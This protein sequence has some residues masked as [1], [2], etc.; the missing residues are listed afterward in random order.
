MLIRHGCRGQVFGYHCHSASFHRI[1]LRVLVNTIERCGCLTQL[2]GFYNK[3][4]LTKLELYKLRPSSRPAGIASR[5]KRTRGV[6]AVGCRWDTHHQHTSGR[7][8]RP[9]AVAALWLFIQGRPTKRTR[10]RCVRGRIPLWALLSLLLSVVG[11]RGRR[12][13]RGPAP[14][15][16]NMRSASPELTQGTSAPKLPA[17]GHAALHLCYP[18]YHRVMRT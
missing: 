13:P 15:F 17:H 12:V 4:R 14:L 7:H 9:S 1:H 3:H 2:K 10:P 11:A 6:A 8:F 18:I 16:G 5:R